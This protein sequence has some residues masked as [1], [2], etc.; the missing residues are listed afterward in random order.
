[1]FVKFRSTTGH[2]HPHWRQVVTNYTS[3]LRAMGRSEEQ[4]D[5]ILRDLAPEFF[6]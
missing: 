5:A 4:I 3:I 6:G 2:E 1:M